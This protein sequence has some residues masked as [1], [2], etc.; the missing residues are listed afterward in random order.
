MKPFLKREK[1]IPNAIFILNH[2]GRIK[3]IYQSPKYGKLLKGGSQE[4]RF[5]IIVQIISKYPFSAS[6][7]QRFPFPNRSQPFLIS[8]LLF[9]NVKHQNVDNE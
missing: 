7:H 3:G 8:M 9:F 5:P 1:F 4:V 6:I 2:N